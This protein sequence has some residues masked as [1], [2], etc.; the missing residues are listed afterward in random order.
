MNA[1]FAFHDLA[2]RTASFRDDVLHGL[3]QVQKALPPKY[4]YDEVGSA[5]F[6]AICVLQEY[7]PTRVE[8]ALLERHAGD[9]A[10]RIGVD[11]A[12]IEFG[13]G[14]S[15]KSR[16]LIEAARPAVYVPIDISGTALHAAGERLQRD[17]PALPIVAVCADYSRPLR[18]PDLTAFAPRQRV[19]FFPGST[20]G[21]FDPQESVQF[22]R[23]AAHLAGS[24]G[25]LVIGV[26]VPKERA[27][28][29]AAYDDPQG[30]TA[31]FN[32]NLLARIN[33]ELGA[34]FD[35]R[36]FRHR[37]RYSERLSRIEMHLE[38]CRPQQ[39]RIGAETFAFGAGE[40]IHTE[41]SYKYSVPQFEALA[42]GAGFVPRASW[43]DAAGLFSLHYMIC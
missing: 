28:L 24:G 37:A 5:L 8:T 7:Y 22:L 1:H 12:L 29:E 19:I 32:L 33:R 38:S 40:T 23:N 16:V 39:V 3:A 9:I 42:A 2:P 11:A 30:V 18:L 6:E 25:S 36:S 43:V 14:A 20:I 17:F 13:S 15:R 10:A 41:N 35:L 34:N 21:N 26:D 4:F 27:V 31:A